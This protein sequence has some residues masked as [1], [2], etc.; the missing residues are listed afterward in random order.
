MSTS[1]SPER[2]VVDEPKAKV[3]EDRVTQLATAALAYPE[4]ASQQI[5]DGRE[6]QTG[7]QRFHLVP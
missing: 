1:R 4:P 2:R 7:F 6:G 5:V 3:L